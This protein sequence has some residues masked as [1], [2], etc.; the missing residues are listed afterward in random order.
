M[1]SQ[2]YRTWLPC[3]GLFVVLSLT[4]GIAFA[5]VSPAAS[6]EK[7]DE[8]ALEKSLDLPT[9]EINAD[10]SPLADVIDFL[11]DSTGVNIVVEWKTIEAAGIEKKIPVS[12]HTA[13]VKL[14]KAL[15]L[16]F[17]NVALGGIRLGYTLKDGVILVTTRDVVDSHLFTRLYDIRD[18]LLFAGDK[19]A[20]ETETADYLVSA[21]QR[22]A[23]TDPDVWDGPQYKAT[24]VH[25]HIVVQAPLRHLRQTE[26]FLA[27]LRRNER[28]QVMLNMRLYSVPA[29]TLD[30]PEYRKLADDASD[31]A[32]NFLILD[33]Q[34]SEALNKRLS[35]NTQVALL[36]SP[37]IATLSGRRGH[38]AIQEP[39]GYISD[40]KSP[41]N[42]FGEFEPV[43]STLLTGTRI[44]V[45][46]GVASDRQSVVLR[47]NAQFTRFSGL[48]ARLWAN[49]PPGKSL[50]IGIPTLDIAEGADTV[51]RVANGATLVIPLRQS[52]KKPAGETIRLLLVTPTIVAP[53]PAKAAP[54]P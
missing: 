51:T 30:N 46:A 2:V 53:E 41:V 32:D 6:Q 23:L 37:R 17:N 1:L 20:A 36:S 26:E 54:K 50:I 31:S 10:N 43:L 48:K 33:A 19:P 18:L 44:D 5:Q 47:V 12:L 49:S 8:A 28:L 16:I 35:G 21:I 22:V 11:R 45:H 25:G 14:S 13:P 15:D 4:A 38:A 24:Q 7:A 29:A 42:P 40:Y 39:H 34:R 52:D 9:K 27:G 3:L